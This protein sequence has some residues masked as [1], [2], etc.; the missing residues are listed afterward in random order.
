VV[1]ELPDPLPG[2]VATDLLEG[3]RHRHVGPRPPAG[4]Q[5]VVQR[6]LDQCVG[7]RVPPRRRFAEHSRG[8]R[9]VAQLEQGVFIDLGDP[10]E[11]LGIEVSADDRGQ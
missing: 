7:E 9:P 5:T 11:Q 4:R 8:D 3:L 1:G 2:I 10:A 6:V